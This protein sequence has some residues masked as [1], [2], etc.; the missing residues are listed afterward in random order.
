MAEYR[1]Q[2]ADSRKVPA[3]SKVGS[4]DVNEYSLLHTKEVVDG[5]KV[6]SGFGTLVQRMM[7]R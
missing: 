6:H 3:M 5:T 4:I 7:M 2:V 1:R